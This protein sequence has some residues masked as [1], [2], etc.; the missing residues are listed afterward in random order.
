MAIELKC[1]AFLLEGMSTVEDNYS[2]RVPEHRVAR[3]A[4]SI[5]PRVPAPD[6]A[7]IN[8]TGEIWQ[9][10][11]E[12]LEQYLFELRAALAQGRARLT[13]TNIGWYRYGV[14]E[15]FTRSHKADRAGYLCASVA[16]TFLSDDPFWYEDNEPTATADL[17]GAG[18]LSLTNNGLA[19]TPFV[20][21]V[22][23]TSPG[24]AGEI[25]NVIITNTTTSL[26]LKWTGGVLELN[27]KLIFDTRNGQ[28]KYGG[29][30]AINDAADSQVY[31]EL[32]PGVNNFAY[33]GP[34][35]V[36]ITVQWTERWY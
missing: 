17:E 32:V 9:A 22:E 36:T 29:G 19:S 6:S 15:K 2:W 18:T 5:A 20:F 4:G 12:L 28:V 8:L 3:R 23:R 7:R 27:K 30:S 16:M 10:N 26:Q 24:V 11:N 31:M 25:P 14:I 21:V 35:D 33:E 1:G 34:G 13:I